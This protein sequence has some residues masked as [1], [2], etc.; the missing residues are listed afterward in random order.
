MALTATATLT[1]RKFITS[2][3]CMRSDN[4]HIVYVPPVKHNIAYYVAEKPSGGFPEAFGSIIKRI[5]E[6]KDIGRIIIFC[7]TYEA[8]TSI[9]YYFKTKLGEYYTKPVGSP[10]YVQYRVV[11]MNTHCTHASV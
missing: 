6:D 3:L 2:S 4:T 1:T 9:F 11:D 8:V 5:K 7:R 10:N